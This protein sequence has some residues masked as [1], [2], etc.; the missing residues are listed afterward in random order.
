MF[1][2]KTIF[3]GGVELF[4]EFMKEGLWIST[5]AQERGYGKY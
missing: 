2:F 1:I 5:I 4:F 3:L